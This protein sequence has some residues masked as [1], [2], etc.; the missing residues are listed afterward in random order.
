MKFQSASQVAVGLIPVNGAKKCGKQVTV[1]LYNGKNS[2]E[3]TQTTEKT[4]EI[5]VRILK[6]RP[7][8]TA[9]QLAEELGLTV[10]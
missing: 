4:A 1:I 6:E 3:T 10:D 8:S 7:Y 5:I 2:V 9:G